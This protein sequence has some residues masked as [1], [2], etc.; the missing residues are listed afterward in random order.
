MKESFNRST[1]SQEKVKLQRLH[2]DLS[3]IQMK[4]IHGYQYFLVAINDTTRAVWIQHLRS[5]E[6]AEV[7]PIF[8]QLQK[9]LKWE[10]NTKVIFV[11]ADNGKGEFGLMFQEHLLQEGMQFKP[12]PP[13][14]HSMN[15]VAERAI[16]MV[17]QLTRSILYQA[18]LPPT[19]WCYATEHAVWIRNRIPTSA[20]P[21]G[22]DSTAETPYES[23]NSRKPNVQNL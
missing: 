23:Y 2:C 7:V 3:G 18:R 22:S 20:L 4:S 10:A 15:R 16:Q 21:F 13:Y 9:E 8:K 19:M 1:D 12:C 5:K 17:D 14:K 11:R 6:A